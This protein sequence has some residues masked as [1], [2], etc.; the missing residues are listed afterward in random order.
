MNKSNGFY[1]STH[2]SNSTSGFKMFSNNNY[3]NNLNNNTNNIYNYIYTNISIKKEK[4]NPQEKQEKLKNLI[5]TKFLK[6]YKI[7]KPDTKVEDEVAK[8]VHG[9]KYD[10][11]DFQELEEKIKVHMSETLKNYSEKFTLK[12]STYTTNPSNINNIKPTTSSS[13]KR[14]FS[15]GNMNI[16]NINKGNPNN[17]NYA[18]SPKYDKD[19][20]LLSSPDT[21]NTKNLN[22]FNTNSNQG[23]Q[24]NSSNK[25]DKNLLSE[26]Q[27][28]KSEND[29]KEKDEQ[30]LEDE[31]NL[32][33]E[34]RLDDKKDLERAEF[35][36]I[37]G[38]WAA[39]NYYLSQKYIED[40]MNDKLREIE[41]K[42]RQK[43]DLENQIKQKQIKQKE[44]RKEEI[45][46]ANSINNVLSL[47]NITE[48]QKQLEMKEKYKQKLDS[49][50]RDEKLRKSQEIFKEKKE[51]KETSKNKLYK[52]Y[53][54]Y[55]ILII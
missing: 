15:M 7:N 5:I 22:I 10:Q 35:N 8:F 21:A 44:E 46:F 20:V 34:L 31:L 12:Y 42:K 51:A 52:S 30:V 13:V 18:I 4:L 27:N 38:E 6:K 55:L 9:D 16:N 1:T 47:I 28:I 41:V 48:K 32:S 40:K 3:N 14:T 26:N 37:G 33:D 54:N 50:V 11:K 24:F 45:D 53:I 23:N 49:Q 19:I 39:I 25:F 29:N 43:F 2:R 36:G 17:Y